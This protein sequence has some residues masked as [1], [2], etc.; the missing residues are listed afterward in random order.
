MPWSLRHD[1]KKRVGLNNATITD[2]EELESLRHRRYS[3]LGDHFGPGMQV[4]GAFGGQLPAKS[5]ST[6]GQAFGVR[7]V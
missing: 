1:A 4:A 2:I 3:P 6:C 5:L 7:R